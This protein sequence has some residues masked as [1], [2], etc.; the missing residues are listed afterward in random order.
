MKRFMSA[1][2]TVMFVLGASIASAAQS[3]GTPQ[4]DRREHR[5]QRRI[6]R[7]V[8][9]G[10]LTRHEAKE[11]ERQEARTQAQE[12]AAKADG[13]VT[14]RERAHLQRRLNRTS[15]HIT[16]QRHDRQYRRP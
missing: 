4:V 2:L 8:R 13:R 5:Q 6:R 16:R 9:S 11:L 1:L 7:G 12:A 3:S 10:T 14:R 15:R